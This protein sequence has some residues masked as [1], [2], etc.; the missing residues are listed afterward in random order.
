MEDQ[1]KERA[2]ALKKKRRNRSLVPAAAASLIVIALIGGFLLYQ[3]QFDDQTPVAEQPKQV[4]QDEKLVAQPKPMVSQ[5]SPAD[6]TDPGEGRD[7]IGDIISFS[8]TTSAPLPQQT[9][10]STLP[11]VK[12]PVAEPL[13]A[14]DIYRDAVVRI[15]QFYAGLDQKRY[16]R[17]YHLNGTSEDYFSTLSQ[18]ALDNPPIV[19]GETDDLFNVLKNTA[20]F[21][22]VVGKKNIIII[23]SILHEERQSY[24]DILAAYFLLSQK[25]EYLENE[26][27]LRVTDEALLDYAGFFL[28]T[29]GGRLYLFRRDS[30]SRMLVSYYAIQIVDQANQEAR[31]IY[32]IDIK[33]AVAA[34]IEELETSNA[35]LQLKERYLDTLYD[36]QEKY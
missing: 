26:F 16:I 21:F 8:Q 22:R 12:E 19:A 25:P 34:L 28:N 35:K 5:S 18:K 31:N 27:A 15:R 20:H 14:Q 23:K 17:G 7:P 9:Q 3:Q 10:P 13:I 33:P 24:E 1:I 29:M 36:L 32:G 2:E 6:T 11:P 4:S 30:V